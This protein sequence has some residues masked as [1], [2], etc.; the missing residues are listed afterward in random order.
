MSNKYSVVLAVMAF[1]AVALASAL[2]S[3]DTELIF[4]GSGTY[5]LNASSG[6]TGLLVGETTDGYTVWANS[7]SATAT[8]AE[9]PTA[10]CTSGTT[11]VATGINAVPPT[12]LTGTALVD[13]GAAKLVVSNPD[14][15]YNVSVGQYSYTLPY[16]QFVSSTG[17]VTSGFA[18]IP[19]AI[20]AASNGGQET[21]TLG[22]ISSL[23]QTDTAYFGLGYVN[24][25]ALATSMSSFGGV[26]V[27]A[28]SLLVGLTYKGDF[29]ESGT[30][31][32]SGLV[33][34]E[35]G[36]DDI[37]FFNETIP[38]DQLWQNGDYL[39]QGTVTLSGLV[40]WE[41]SYDQENFFG[42]LPVLPS[43]VGG[44]MAPAFSMA[45]AN[46][47]AVPEPN[48]FVL[49]AAAAAAY[50]LARWRRRRV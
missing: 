5:Q 32:L 34:W 3:A 23:V 50:A 11:Y 7:S 19:A 49:L 46:L 6:T 39:N 25:G 21:G 14:A 29:N 31:S 1:T 40:A 43:A 38:P 27:T 10:W 20:V 28:D 36:Y 26:T 37:N 35:N 44:N 45:P 33:A 22:V 13:V 30:V 17:A 12:N 16:N 42:G 47:T 2:A 9:V 48:T 8:V 4:E 24:N 41:N 18:A 15:G